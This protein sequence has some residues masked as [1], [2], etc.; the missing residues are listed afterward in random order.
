MTQD[1][2]QD[3]LKQFVQ[4]LNKFYEEKEWKQ[5]HSPK[6]LAMGVASEAGE[7]LQIFR[8]L[9]EA[10]SSQLDSKTLE[11][12]QDEIGDVFIFLAYLADA[13]GMDAIALAERKLE[14][15]IKKYSSDFYKG[16]KDKALA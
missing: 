6:N 13:L 4:K 12:V 9:T 2:T 16:R 8:F 7:L 11:L 15:S 5:F 14:K 10:E 1:R 3:R